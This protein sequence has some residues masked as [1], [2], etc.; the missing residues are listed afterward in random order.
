MNFDIIYSEHAFKPDNNSLKYFRKLTP[1][2]LSDLTPAKHY[3]T[4]LDQDLP[5]PIDEKIK[6]VSA[7]LR[8]PRRDIFVEKSVVYN[9]FRSLDKKRVVNFLS[10]FLRNLKIHAANTCLK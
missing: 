3:Q 2:E 8:C 5:P 10:L 9:H 6:A 7:C 1:E 4:V